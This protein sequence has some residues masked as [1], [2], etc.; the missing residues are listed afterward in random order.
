MAE[1]TRPSKRT[2]VLND[3][4]WRA[5][6]MRRQARAARRKVARALRPRRFR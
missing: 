1:P 6:E 2:A 4:R 5:R 3:V